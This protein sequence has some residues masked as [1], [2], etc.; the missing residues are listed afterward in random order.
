M[1]GPDAT[2]AA[3]A[4]QVQQTTM[5]MPQVP[6]QELA[7]HL[8]EMLSKVQVTADES[9]LIVVVQARGLL[10]GIASGQLV[11]GRPQVEAKT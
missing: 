3:T 11:V 4:P 7:K 9:S 8:L 1:A 6:P 2:D 5:T 10:G